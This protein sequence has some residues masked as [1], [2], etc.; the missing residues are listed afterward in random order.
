MP[1]PGCTSFRWSAAR[2]PTPHLCERLCGRRLPSSD[3]PTN[4]AAYPVHE[5]QALVK[6]RMCCVC[7]VAP[8]ARI[9][10]GDRNG[11]DNPAVF[12]MPCYH[13][14]HYSKDGQLLYDDF[15]VFPYYHEYT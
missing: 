3:D 1:R 13:A 15:E 12:C 6:H 5:F 8:G 9:V 7:A 14:L 10:Y 2:V 4:A 11:D